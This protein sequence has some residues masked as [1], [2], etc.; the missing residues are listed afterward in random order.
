[1]KNNCNL[2]RNLVISQSVSVQTVSGKNYLL[3]DI[4]NNA[5]RN[6]EKVCLVVAQ[7]I[8]NTATIDTEVAI[9][10][11][12]DTTTVYPLINSCCTP[13]TAC[14]IKPR[15]KYPLRVQTTNSSAIFKS[16]MN[17]C[18][19]HSYDFAPIAIPTATQAVA[20]T[21]TVPKAKE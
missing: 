14:A 5:F 20:R 8:P 17:L 19:S 13:V 1:M 2:C 10:I 18:S 12:G 7:N 6:G 4:P 11:N 21:K 9:S 3:I 16:L 15:R